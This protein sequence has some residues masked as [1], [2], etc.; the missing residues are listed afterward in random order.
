MKR[1]HLFLIVA[2][3]AGLFFLSTA[4]MAVPVPGTYYSETTLFVPNNIIDVGTWKE[5]FGPSGQGAGE[6]KLTA[7]AVDAS[8]VAEPKPE[9]GQWSI[10]MVSPTGPAKQWELSDGSP[11]LGWAWN[12]VTSYSGVLAIALS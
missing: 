8:A 1:K 2:V 10:D 7:Q 5:V 12:W 6:S 3:A 11:I 9:S 4:A